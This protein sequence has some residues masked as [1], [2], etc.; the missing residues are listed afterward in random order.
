[1]TEKN[2]YRKLPSEISG[3]DWNRDAET[4]MVTGRASYPRLYQLRD[5]TF[6]CGIDGYCFRSEDQGTTWSSGYDYRQNY[7][8]KT[9]EGKDYALTCA[10]SAFFEMED[11]TLLVGYRATGYPVADKSLFCAKLLVSQSTDGGKSW[12]AHSTMCEYYDKEGQ[13]KGVWEPHFGRID[14]VLTCFY[15]NDSRDVIVPPYQNIESLQWIDGRW[16]NRTI[17]ADGTANRSRDGMPVWQQLSNGRFVCVIEGWYP[18]TA[19]LCIQIMDSPDGRYWSKPKTVYR[20]PDGGV[21][22]PYITELPGG[23]FLITFQD[24]YRHCCAILSD[25][26]AV[27]ELSPEHFTEPVN[28]FGTEEGHFSMWN[29]Q[30]LTER[31]LYVVTGTD[32]SPD[33]SGTVIK[34]IPVECLSERYAE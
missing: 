10:N 5:G 29:A 33:G 14:G 11:G 23:R 4:I 13:F 16:T 12:T 7:H 30:Y 26:T 22:A 9:P 28:V 3:I 1:M 19:E 20:S 34:R 21:G 15:A 17:L 32:R 27:E 2:N 6:L 31:Y 25:G 8:I 18:G 24:P